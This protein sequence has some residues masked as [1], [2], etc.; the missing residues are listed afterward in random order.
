[1]ALPSIGAIFGFDVNTSVLTV[2]EEETHASTLSLLEKSLPN[3]LN[4]HDFIKFFE[5]DST[6]VTF[7]IKDDALHLKPF[8]SIFSPPPEA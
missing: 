2:T 5:T 7:N 4:V 1:M 6:K 3:S 8:I